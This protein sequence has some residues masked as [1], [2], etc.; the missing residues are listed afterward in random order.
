MVGSSAR[1]EI[2]LQIN[3]Q[4]YFSYFSSN[5]SCFEHIESFP[6]I[7]WF[8]N[9]FV[10]PYSGGFF[11]PTHFL[12][13]ISPRCDHVFSLFVLVFVCPSILF[14]LI[15]FSI[16]LI[17]FRIGRIGLDYYRKMIMTFKFLSIHWSW[18][19][20]SGVNRVQRGITPSN[21]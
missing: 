2:Y 7:S 1:R 13:V 12:E 14:L 16:A 9:F 17:N 21:D 5:F 20:L 8:W 19:F 10:C 4:V 6:V 18:K 11:L 15:L 3:K